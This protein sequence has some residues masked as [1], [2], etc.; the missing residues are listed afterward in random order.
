MY[1]TGLRR[2]LSLFEFTFKKWYSP[3]TEIH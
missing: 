1:A 3:W 2:I